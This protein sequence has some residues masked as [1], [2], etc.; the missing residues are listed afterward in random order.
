MKNLDLGALAAL[1]LQ[2]LRY[3]GCQK[4]VLRQGSHTNKFDFSAWLSLEELDLRGFKQI[5]SLLWPTRLKVLSLAETGL[6][7]RLAEKIFNN[8]NLESLQELDLSANQVTE[9]GPLLRLRSLRK[10]NLQDNLLASRETV[11]RIIDSMRELTDLDLS[12]NDLIEA[13]DTPDVSGLPE[14]EGAPAKLASLNLANQIKIKY[15]ENHRQLGFLRSWHFSGLRS[16]DLSDNCLT[17][18]IF[19]DLSGASFR[20]QRLVLKNNS[21]EGRGLVPF[22]ESLGAGLSSTDLSCNLIRGDLSLPTL[23]GLQFLDLSSN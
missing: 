21:L 14:G 2:K 8:P 15:T 5:S 11:L 17:D 10:L 3:L 20:L 12:M 18:Q 6:N 7:D 4:I 13:E 9:V 23:R 19:Q 16:L 1:N 22:L